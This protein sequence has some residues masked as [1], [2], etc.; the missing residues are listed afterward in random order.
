MINM[1]YKYAIYVGCVVVNGQ[2]T[3][4]DRLFSIQIGAYSKMT[5]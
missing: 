4:R 5:L 1:I 2:Q 3:D